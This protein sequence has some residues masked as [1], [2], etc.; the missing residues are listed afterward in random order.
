MKKS[1][2]QDVIFMLIGKGDTILP[3]TYVENTVDGIYKASIVE[4]AIGQAYNL[5]DGGEITAKSYLDKFVKFNSSPARIVYL[6]YVLPYGAS[7]FYEILANL[8]LLKKGV[9]SRAQ[10]KWKQAKVCFD[11]TKAKNELGWKPE[12]SMNDGLKRTFMWYAKR[13]GS[14]K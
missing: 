11:N 7:L 12:I 1:R 4:K 9:T 3:L 8:G 2:Y 10:L 14:K 6:P 5:V 13:Y